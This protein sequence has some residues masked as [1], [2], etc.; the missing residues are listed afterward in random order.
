[1][2]HKLPFRIAA[3]G[4]I[5]T[6]GLSACDG[7]H[8]GTQGASAAH[9]MSASPWLGKP[10]GAAPADLGAREAP[11]PFLG[12]AA[13]S[14]VSDLPAPPPGVPDLRMNPVRM[15]TEWRANLA[16]NG[17]ERLAHAQQSR[18]EEV[19]R[20]F[21]EAGVTFPPHDLLFRIFKQER[22]FEVWAGDPG[23]SMKL[24][25]T[26]G[27]CAASGDLGPKR[28]EGDM[29]VPEGYYKVGYYHP[30]SAYYLSAQVNYPNASDKVR[31]GPNPGGDILIHGNCASI[32]C[33]SMTDERI[34]E[35]YLIGWG[36]FMSGRPTSI[37]IFPSHDID[38]LLADASRAS[39]HAF[40]REIKPGL[41][42]F[43]RTHRIPT[44]RV[45]ADGRYVVTPSE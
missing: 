4:V 8:R 25:A 19:Q 36:A 37:E 39:N 12:F 9:P 29:Q 31:G 28:A 2:R 35:I 43:D 16:W 38:S 42:A 26:Y 33:V 3:A 13:P 41:E 7:A 20:L 17:H 24:V 30:M 21:H 45:E 18:G 40:W 44:V 23:A 11:S 14:A 5:L 27:I 22:E 1:M 32:G 6:I 34:E 15:P 10:P